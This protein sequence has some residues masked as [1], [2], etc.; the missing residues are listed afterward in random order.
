[1]ES[2]SFAIMG[3]PLRLHTAATVIIES[4]N[5]VIFFVFGFCMVISSKGFQAQRLRPETRLWLFPRNLW[6]LSFRQ[7]G[8]FSF[9]VTD[10]HGIMVGVPLRESHRLSDGCRCL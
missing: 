4:V 1:M 5:T 8:I 9:G 7:T 3:N 10:H 2:P 6:W